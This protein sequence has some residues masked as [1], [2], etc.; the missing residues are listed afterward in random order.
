M[1]KYL[2]MAIYMLVAFIINKLLF[3]LVNFDFWFI[4]FFSGMLFKEKIGEKLLEN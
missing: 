3:Y 2:I 4:Y 1:K